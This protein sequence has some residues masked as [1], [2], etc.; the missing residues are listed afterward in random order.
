MSAKGRYSSADLLALSDAKSKT[1]ESCRD[2]CD[3]DDATKIKLNRTEKR[4]ADTFPRCPEQS[5]A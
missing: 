5:Y 4:R 1:R 2:D 3:E